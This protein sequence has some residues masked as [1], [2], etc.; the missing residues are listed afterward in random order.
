M[1]PSMSSK[2]ELKVKELSEENLHLNEL[3]TKCQH[4]IHSSGLEVHWS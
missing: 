4:N 1:E 3:I 2:I